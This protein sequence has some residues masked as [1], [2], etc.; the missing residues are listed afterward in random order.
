MDIATEITRI[1]KETGQAEAELKA[2]LDQFKQKGYSDQAAIAVLKSQPKIK[3][4]LGG[5]LINDALMVPFAKEGAREVST[6]RGPAKVANVSV[7]IQDG[8]KWNANRLSLWDDAIEANL[9]KFEVGKPVT[10]TLRVREDKISIVGD[11]KPNATP[12]PALSKLAEQVGLLKLSQVA[13]AAGSDALVGGIVGRAFTTPYGNGLELSEVGSNP[14]T[15]YL[16]G[17]KTAK[18]GDQVIVAGRIVDKN[19][20]ISVRGVILG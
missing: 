10:A 9:A 3:N 18:E 11:V 15:V 16:S 8:G 13:M 2:L 20:A 14:V 1:A 4:R 7:F 12:V 17:D 5:K 6:T 19:G